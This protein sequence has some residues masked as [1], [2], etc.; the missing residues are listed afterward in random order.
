MAQL[1]IESFD[2]WNTANLPGPFASVSGSA[3]IV[4][5]FTAN[6][7]SLGT[8]AFAMLP[9]VS[10]STGSLFVG[11]RFNMTTGGENGGIFIGVNPHYA[12][13]K[14]NSD[15]SV[16]FS[17]TGGGTVVKSASGVVPF[18]AGVWNYLELA[19]NSIS[20]NSVCSIYINGVSVASG[21]V[22]QF[23]DLPLTSVAIQANI[24]G[25][26]GGNFLIDD[27]Y[28]ND[29]TT[30][31]N[32]TVLGPLVVKPY[33]AT[34]NGRVNAWTANGATP[35]YNCVKGNPAQIVDFIDSTTAG[36]VDAYVIPNP[37]LNFSVVYG[38]QLTTY[39]QQDAGG[40]HTVEAGVGDGTA[41]SFGAAYGLPVG[42]TPAFYSTP[43]SIDPRSGTPWTLVSIA[44]VQS[45]V[46]LAS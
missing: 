18:G 3:A 38:A 32:N 22:N 36:N 20:T 16:Q 15:G 17:S 19:M 46:K 13:L 33:L 35:N 21:V 27:L 2:Y 42:T 10:K 28:L 44:T 41:E 25:G 39:G 40:T 14:I 29:E 11:F 45:A 7:L 1:F 31:E 8:N 4:A 24:L 5:G 43:F 23:A 6:A 34:A 12:I 9:N 30:L 37:A 26:G